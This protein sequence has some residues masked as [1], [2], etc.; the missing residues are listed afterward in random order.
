MKDLLDL[1]ATKTLLFPTASFSPITMLQSIYYGF[2]P[3]N[4]LKLDILM[5]V[6]GLSYS[7]NSLSQ[8]VFGEGHWV[9]TKYQAA[10]CEVFGDYDHDKK[11]HL[12]CD[13][14]LLREFI[15]KIC[16]SSTDIR[17]VSY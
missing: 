15:D 10:V 2:N 5:P 13:V 3:T 12:A 11:N 8:Y 9:C 1:V 17:L 14:L 4:L 6:Y 16:F 7:K